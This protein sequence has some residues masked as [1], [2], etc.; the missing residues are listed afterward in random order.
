M[1]DKLFDV[2][3]VDLSTKKIRFMAQGKTERN[4]EAIETI[5]V[6]RRGVDVEFFTTVPAGK[7][8]EGD[9]CK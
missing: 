6:M 3:A 7:Y 4:A 2:I 9:I 1:N 8:K 5:A